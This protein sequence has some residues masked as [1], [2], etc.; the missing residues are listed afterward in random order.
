MSCTYQDVIRD[1]EAQLRHKFLGTGMAKTIS[2]QNMIGRI[3]W[4]SQ[5]RIKDRTEAYNAAQKKV[6]T[7]SNWAVKNFGEKFRHGWASIDNSKSDAVLVN[8]HIPNNFKAAYKVKKEQPFK[9]DI[10]YYLGDETLMQQEEGELFQLSRQSEVPPDA[11]LDSFL[12]DLLQK[13]GISVEYVDSLK[14]R[15]GIDAVAMADLANR[16]V[17]VAK[18]RA[19]ITTLP[20]EASHFITEMLRG[21]KTLYDAMYKLAEQSAEYNEVKAAYSDVYKGDKDMLIRETMGKL[22]SDYLIKRNKSMQDLSTNQSNLINRVWRWVK[23]LFSKVDNSDLQAKIDDIYGGVANSLMKNQISLDPSKIDQKGDVFYQGSAL[24]EEII[25][26]IKRLE[27]RAEILETRASNE[28]D[29]KKASELRSTASIIRDRIH[30]KEDPKAA[31]VAYLSYLNSEELSV[32]IRQLEGYRKDP[33]KMPFSSAQVNRMEEILEVNE[34]NILNL[35]R[36]LKWDNN[37][38]E[39]YDAAK[40][41]LEL[42]TQSLSEIKEFLDIIN[43]RKTQEILLKN[44]AKG[45]KLDVTNILNSSIGDMGYLSRWFGPLRVAKN[46][47][48]RLI[49]NLVSNIYNETHRTVVDEGLELLNLQFELEKAGYKPKNLHDRDSNGNKT[50]FIITDKKWSEYYEAKSNVMETLRKKFDK[51]TYDD[52]AK[53]EL[54]E[55]QRALFNK[56]WSDFHKKYSK[57]DSDGRTV[58]NPPKNYEFE[59]LMRNSAFANYYNKVM[60]IHNESKKVLPP[61]YRSG[62]MQYLL[63]QIRKDIMQTIK[64]SDNPLFSEIKSRIKESFTITEEDIDYGS[65]E[66]LVDINGKVVKKVP[67]HYTKPVD[68]KNQLSDDITSMYAAFY[69][70]ALNFK[71][72]ST[73][74]EDIQVIQRTMGKAMVKPKRA[75][76]KEGAK[77]GAETNDYAALN[78]FVDAYIYG[79]AKQKQYVYL[80]NGKKISVSYLMDKFRAFVRANNLFLNFPT[81]IAG[82]TKGSLDSKLEDVLGTLTTQESKWFAERELDSNLHHVF[83]N[84]GKRKKSSK[85]EQMFDRFQV[86]RNTRE[87]FQRLDLTDI[88]SRTTT[89]NI[90]YGSY[91]LFDYRLRGKLALAV[92]DNMRLIDGEFMTKAQ[93]ERRE[94]KDA[95]KWSEFRDRSFY[96]AFEYKNGKLQVKSQ[97]KDHVT[98]DVQNR[99]QNIIN[100]RG[101]V[102]TGIPNHM[103][104]SGVYRRML[105]RMLMLHRGWMVTGAVERFKQGGINYQTG[106]FEEGYYRTVGKAVASAFMEKGPIKAKLASFNKLSE[107]EKRNLKKFMVDALFTVGM[108][109]LARIFQGMADDDD[110][111]HK[112]YLAYQFNRFELEQAAF[113]NPKEIPNI[114]NSPSA[115]ISTWEDIQNMFF[116]LFDNEEV[117][118]GAYKG[119]TQREKFLIKRS[120]LKNLWELPHIKDKNK[121]IKTQIL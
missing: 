70:M 1:T 48:L 96:N 20:E 77:Q 34:E 3:T 4:G 22:L 24:Y 90:L 21:N 111:W 92:M 49:Y 116:T 37:F 25:N 64:D 16:V 27:K 114:L 87:I 73:R 86:S 112:D 36:I 89:D 105:G 56:T 59:K 54:T 44:R 43:K 60:E 63:P 55:E 26:N 57:Q 61:K 115:A 68:N 38:K 45:S 15:K 81:M 121:Y 99:V 85:M 35:N 98:N 65:Q 9:R 2:V 94:K 84:L 19:D 31:T 119:M 67:V 82:H 120:L 103:D 93:F 72:L 29:E 6:E 79:E 47:T 40:G 66:I 10:N 106:E 74:V 80:P 42:A 39:V 32:L 104:R 52:V 18:D 12:K 51:D 58:P 117:S 83:A 101:A 110:E 91:E 46:E 17:N 7:I 53:A 113:M 76:S 107:Y 78:D 109:I 50:G 69:E 14:T 28:D 100:E 23:S 13:N 75:T 8:L 97:F 71:G 11:E 41:Q 95:R 62:Y 5:Y 102:I 33:S 30:D 118:Y 88:A 108:M